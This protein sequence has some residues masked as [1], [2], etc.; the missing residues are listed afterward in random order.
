MAENNENEKSSGMLN[1]E[2][3]LEGKMIIDSRGEEVGVCRAVNIGEDGQIGLSFEVEINEKQV[4]PSQT[5]PYSAISKIT[6][7]IELRVPINIK[8]AQSA[9]EIKTQDE[10]IETTEEI[11]DEVEEE[12]TE[13]IT[14]VES[15]EE[16]V[17]EDKIVE[18]EELEVQKPPKQHETESSDTL[19]EKTVETVNKDLPIAAEKLIGKIETPQADATEQLSKALEEDEKSETTGIKLSSSNIEVKELT[20]GLEESV[21]KIDKLFKL[22]SEGEEETR[23]EAIKALTYLTKI[24]PELGLS[25]IPKL[26]ELN[27]EPKQEVRLNIAQQLVNISEANP[28][29]FNGYYLELLENAYEEPIEEIREQLMKSLHEIAMRDSKNASVGLEEFLEDVIIGKRVPE[30]PAKVLHDVTLRVVSGNFMLTKI[31]IRAR[32]KIIGQGGKLGERCAEELEDY[33]A[34]LIGLTIIET[35]TPKDAE[36]LMK[37]SNIK[38]LGPVFI[39][40][41]NQMIAAYKEGS[42][43]QLEEVVDKKIEIST[44]VIEKFFEIKINK[45]LEGVK[46]VPME[47]FLGNAIIQPDEAE[48]IIYRL[49][50]QKRI[51]ASINMS[52]GR[53]FITSLDAEESNGKTQEKPKVAKE[54]VKKAPTKKKTAT[55]SSAKK[56]TTTTKKKPVTKSSANKT[57]TT[58]K[59]KTTSATKTP[60]PKKTTS[61]SKNTAAEDQSDDK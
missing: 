47:V 46:N 38:K 17:S 59:K 40:V 33:N 44:E 12:K 1:G 26:M 32:L 37:N 13:E 16:R 18:K 53:T 58:S 36:K 15:E 56:T 22:L 4:I 34:T 2:T 25:L 23:I 50:V 31:A 9:S 57:N 39:E 14:I 42:I 48:Q 29:L 41:I 52:N 5:I 20:K 43:N 21:R 35:L 54:P 28:E 11:E 30:V 60:S 3:D 49:V 55:K 8:V 45:T 19:V 51:N 10:E 6:D 7:V 61:D 27:N 24:S